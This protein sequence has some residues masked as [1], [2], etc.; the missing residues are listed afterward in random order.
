MTRLQNTS[1]NII[2][3]SKCFSYMNLSEAFNNKHLKHLDFKQG[4]QDYI[5]VSA[6]LLPI[7][8]ETSF[9]AFISNFCGNAHVQTSGQARALV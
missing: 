9:I 3:T 8:F 6:L 5:F 1:E 7:D 4:P 2:K